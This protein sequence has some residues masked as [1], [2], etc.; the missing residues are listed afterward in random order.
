MS[1]I[2]NIQA[3]KY[4]NILHYEWQGDLIDKTEDYVLIHCKPGRRLKHY[5]KETTFTI[6]NTSVE[7]FSLKEWFTVAMEIEQGNVISYYCNI[8][9]PSKLV[10]NNLS[11][12]NLDLDLVKKDETD[13][14]VIDED[15]FEVN[16]SKFGY[17]YELKESAIKALN[18]LKR[19]V[20]EKVFPFNESI[21]EDLKL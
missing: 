4:P 3:L 11:F 19:K 5:T 8:A 9:K 2:I 17:P 16:S 15:E 12:V 18:E 13:W 6:N 20:E 7:Y 10:D 14:Q 21:L 1:E